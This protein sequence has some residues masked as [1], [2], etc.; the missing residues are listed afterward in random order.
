MTIRRALVCGGIPAVLEPVGVFREDGKR[1]DGMSLILWEEGHPL[2]WDFTCSDTMAPSHRDQATSGTGEV[3]C[4]AESLKI[5][6]Y[7]SLTSTYSFAPLLHRNH[8]CLGRGCQG[9]YQKDWTK[10][11]GD[12]GESRSTTFLIQRLAIDVQRGNVAS[13]MATI[14]SSRD[15]EEISNV[16]PI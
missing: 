11:A 1:P 7:S 5:R 14:P 16:P 9:Y 12:T 4:T 13:V 6:K 10:G 2:L 8:G 15:W 3:A